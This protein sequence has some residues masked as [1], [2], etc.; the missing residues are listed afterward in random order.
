MLFAGSIR[1]KSCH[2]SRASLLIEVQT[3]CSL[4]WEIHKDGIFKSHG[5]HHL[6]QEVSQ[7]D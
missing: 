3:E 4:T 6:I 1:K 5:C 2:G 7:N